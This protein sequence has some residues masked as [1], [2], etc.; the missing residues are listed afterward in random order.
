MLNTRTLPLTIAAQESVGERLELCRLLAA[1]TVNRD[2]ENLLINEPQVALQQGYED[3]RF[4]LTQEERDLVL[5]IHAGSLAE[6][7]RILVRTLGEREVV[8]CHY[9]AR[10]EQYLAA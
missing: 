2:F 4:L 1:A 8:R 3:E 5:S 6:L 10:S 9:P 7:A